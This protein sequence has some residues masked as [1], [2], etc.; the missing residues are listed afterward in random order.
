MPQ[1]LDKG[2]VVVTLSAAEVMTAIEQAAWSAAV[3]DN[4]SITVEGYP[5]IERVGGGYQVTYT[6]KE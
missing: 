5:T 4:P 2:R 3:N 1:V 6:K